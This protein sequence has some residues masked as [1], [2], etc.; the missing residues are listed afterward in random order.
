MNLWLKKEMM[1]MRWYQHVRSLGLLITVPKTCISS[2]L[3]VIQCQHSS[4]LSF[5]LFI[6]VLRRQRHTQH[7]GIISYE[8]E[9]SSLT[10]IP[11]C[12]L[13]DPCLFGFGIGVFLVDQI[14]FEVVCL[15]QVRETRKCSK[16]S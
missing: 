6:S 1:M 3:Q 5:A 13:R 11:G 9:N 4:D 10:V 14:S 15:C 7:Y 12:P 2:S 8:L 16:T